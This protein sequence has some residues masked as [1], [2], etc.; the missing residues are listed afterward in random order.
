MEEKKLE[1]AL[2]F[3]VNDTNGKPYYGYTYFG[4]NSMPSSTPFKYEPAIKGTTYVAEEDDIVKE[5]Y[6]KIG[7]ELEIV[8]Q[9]IDYSDFEK[10]KDEIPLMV[11][12]MFKERTVLNTPVVVKENAP[13]PEKN[14]N[15]LLKYIKNLKI[16]A[17]LANLGLVPEIEQHKTK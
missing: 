1:K 14:S 5:K 15:E 11:Q 4:G 7:Y 9:T 3:V 12:K 8:K 10:K 6:R 16:Y 13:E 2:M 17:K